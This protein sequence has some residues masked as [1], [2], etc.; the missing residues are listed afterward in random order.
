MKTTRILLVAVLSLLLNSLAGQALESKGSIPISPQAPIKITKIDNRN[1][2]DVS[3]DYMI[4]GFPYAQNEKGAYSGAV[5]VYKNEKIGTQDNWVFKQQLTQTSANYLGFHLSISGDLAFVAGSLDNRQMY[6]YKRNPNTD[7]WEDQRVQINAEIVKGLS[8]RFKLEGNLLVLTTGNWNRNTQVFQFNAAAKTCLKVQDLNPGFDVA[9]D[10]KTNQLLL[11]GN[12]STNRNVCSLYKLNASQRWDNV[13]RFDSEKKISFLGS[14]AAI[15]GDYIVMGSSRPREVAGEAN[16]VSGVIFH[17]QADGQWQQEEYLSFAPE[18]ISYVSD[19]K[20]S[21]QLLVLGGQGSSTTDPFRFLVYKKSGGKWVKVNGL[22]IPAG[23]KVYG[24]FAVQGANIYVPSYTT[25]G[26][27]RRD[28]NLKQNILVYHVAGTDEAGAPDPVEEETRN[29]TEL[30]IDVPRQKTPYWCWAAVTYSVEKFYNP[31]SAIS[32][33]ALA[34][35]AF[36]QTTC[37]KDPNSSECEKGYD[38]TASFR[39][40]NFLGRSTWHRAFPP[41]IGAD[42]VEPFVSFEAL[43]KEMEAGRPVALRFDMMFPDQSQSFFH[44]VLVVGVYTEG[45]GSSQK[46]MV[47]LKD[48]GNLGTEGDGV[49]KME[50][51]RMKTHYQPNHIEENGKNDWVD[52]T[53]TWY[54]T[55][56]TKRP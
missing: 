36:E 1:T 14:Q 49:T 13:V 44:A 38:F 16:P 8:K 47:I 15:A 52:F 40:R 56:F 55:L 54:Q 53:G 12:S 48:P 46:K 22:Q 27:S 42:A 39:D 20:M 5:Y 43:Q 41:S 3:G 24:C 26:T 28:P 31:S 34:N 51:N 35:D 37:C 25:T 2:I 9:S 30:S 10:P 4:V 33:C 18:A 19:I 21:D 50:Y 32:Q 45:E 29:V 7:V 23:L 6:I 11:G 17:R